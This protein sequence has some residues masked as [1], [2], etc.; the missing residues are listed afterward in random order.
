[1]LVVV[2][3]VSGCGSD[4]VVSVA[5]GG[6]KSVCTENRTGFIHWEELSLRLVCARGVPY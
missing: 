2:R 5:V 1:V 3:T 6:K 4:S